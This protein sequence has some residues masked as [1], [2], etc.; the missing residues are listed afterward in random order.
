MT[1]SL[2]G[3]APKAT[4]STQPTILPAQ[5]DLLNMLTELLKTGATPP[6]ISSY[7]G[8]F[9]APLNSMQQTSLAALEQTALGGPPGQVQ[10]T[11]QQ[12]EALNQGFNTLSDTLNYQAP[13]IDSTAAFQQGVVDPL[14]ENFNTNVLPGVDARF[15]GSA[16]G[17]YSS[18]RQ[19][20]ALNAADDF[21]TTLAQQGSKFAYDTSAANQAAELTANQQRLAAL[22]LVP[23]IAS[24]PSTLDAGIAGANQGLESGYIEQ[25]MRVLQGGQVPYNVAQTQ[26]AGEYQ[27][28]LS[29]LTQEQQ[30]IA[31]LLGAFGSPT[32]NTLGVGSAGSSGIL[33]SLFGA[34]GTAI[35]GIY[36][37]ERLKDDLEQIGDVDGLPLYR[38][39]YKGDTTPRLGFVA[40]DVERR[41][42]AAVSTDASG[43]KM[44]D[45]GHVIADIL[46]AA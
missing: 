34:A 35:G 20:G 12:T 17:A 33:P 30:I 23:S 24:A 9:A 3:S 8:T 19:Q 38:F 41:V 4:F 40:Q 29:G 26:V 37:D 43:Y 10:K 32:V 25:L 45:Y 5:N 16:G 44:V 15:A 28:Y 14:T 42:P 22:G 13:K 39:R 1:S 18:G 27:D 31:A 36:S 7:G 2:F 11:P 21:T 46:E 6:G